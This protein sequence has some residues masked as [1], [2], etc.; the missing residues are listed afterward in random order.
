[1]KEWFQKHQG[2]VLVGSY[3]AGIV[4]M[5]GT[6]VA[7]VIRGDK[8]QIKYYAKANEIQDEQLRILRETKG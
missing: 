7:S 1:M 8:R 3:L 4:T 5:V 6:Y 2:A